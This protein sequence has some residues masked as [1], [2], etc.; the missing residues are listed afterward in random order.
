MK[1]LFITC[2]LLCSAT[3]LSASSTKR[4]ADYGEASRVFAFAS[5]L[6]NALDTFLL[7]VSHDSYITTDVSLGLTCVLK[8]DA[9]Y[10]AEQDEDI[11]STF[12]GCE[13]QV[14]S[15]VNASQTL[16]DAYQQTLLSA[17]MLREKVR[18]VYFDTLVYRSTNLDQEAFNKSRACSARNRH[19][20]TAKL[21]KTFHDNYKR[22]HQLY[23]DERRKKIINRHFIAFK[24][25]YGLYASRMRKISQNIEREYDCD[26]DG[27]EETP[28]PPPNVGVGN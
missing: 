12:Y 11:P 25:G 6:R 10:D 14:Y 22:E 16:F 28:T 5:I 26:R 9:V 23:A 19:T 21:W 27:P 7:T 13:P 2:L 18:A 17:E 3:P 4:I 20:K 8:Y 24:R 15:A 1:I